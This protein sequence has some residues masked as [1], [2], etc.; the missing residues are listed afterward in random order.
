MGFVQIGFLGIF[1]A[2]AIPVILHL[3]RVRRAPRIEL[4]TLRFLREVLRK[5]AR[6]R[7]IERWLLLALR[8]GAVGLLALL[9]ARPYVR[10]GEEGDA[11]AAVAILIDRSGSM[12]VTTGEGPLHGRAL[13]RAVAIV[14]AWGGDANVSV[15]VYDSAVL[16]VLAWESGRSDRGRS[17]AEMRAALDP[18]LSGRFTAGA[19]DH[20][21]A[22]AW[23]RDVLAGTERPLKILYILTD[24]QRSGLERSA[25][26][27]L[28]DGFKLEVVDLGVPFVENVAVTGVSAP[29]WTVRPGEAIELV[30]TVGSFRP[31]EADEVP[32]DLRLRCGEVEREWNETVRLAAGSVAEARFRLE[33]LKEGLWTGVVRARTE[34]DLAFDDERH[35]ALLVAPPIP[36]ALIDGEPRR[37]A[38]LRETYYIETALRLAPRGRSHAASEFEPERFAEGEGGDLPRLEGYGAVVLANVR[39]ID[40]RSA[41]RLAAFVEGGGGLLVTCGDRVA[42]AGYRELGY[43]GLGPGE[44][45]GS[46]RMGAAPWRI[47]AWD[48]THP[49]LRAFE[50]PQQG[51]LRSLVF[52][53]ITRI[54]P[55]EGPPSPDPASD[56]PPSPGPATDGARAIARFQG[57]VPALI[58]TTLGAGKT[59]WWTTS[60]DLDWSDFP[61]SRLFVPF[62]REVL[63]YLVGLATGGRIRQ[64]LVDDLPADAE[65][66]EPGIRDAGSFWEVIHPD[67]SESDPSRCTVEDFTARFGGDALQRGEAGTPPPSGDG[68]GRALRS[69]ELW[70]L[71]L[72]ALLGILALEFLLANR[73]T[74]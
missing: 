25:P 29:S 19:T 17:P 72:L 73:T 53:T 23:G 66:R 34:D 2:A 46:L 30:A 7:A 64:V 3:I 6:R 32:L 4:G 62:V 36:V 51:D 41:R 21:A 24:L 22:I 60:C 63:R 20:G 43:V 44:I 39:T 67:P 14:E 50:D 31:F 16:P 28:P 55:S 26:M 49:A 68:D 59:I 69:E 54:A 40:E 70:P 47:E 56:G 57:G 38:F 71:F 9:F 42:E 10:R 35:V 18:L 37:E 8:V 52:R 45:V 5:N 61:R 74:A 58:E 13:L 65:G 15:A 1:V 33:G 11:G 12:S 27:R 48:E